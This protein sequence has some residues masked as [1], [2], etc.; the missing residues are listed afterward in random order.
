MDIVYLSI[1]I[2]FK[3]ASF[4]NAMEHLSVHNTHLHFYN[5]P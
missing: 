3:D 2:V 1:C 5:P 4:Y